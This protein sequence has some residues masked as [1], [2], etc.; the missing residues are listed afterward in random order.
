MNPAPS[1]ASA[2][3]QATTVQESDAARRR[4]RLCF[5]SALLVAAA[6]AIVPGWP[7]TV[8]AD[9][10]R[11]PSATTAAGISGEAKPS[12]SIGDLITRLTSP[13]A[14]E[15]VAAAEQL[16]FHGPEA[17]SAVPV[18]SG[19]EDDPQASV[20]L[21]VATALWD[22][23]ADASIP[24]RILGR[25]VETDDSEITPAAACV[26][27]RMGPEAGDVLPMLRSAL[28]RSH[29]L[30]RV[31]LAEAVMQIEPR[32]AAAVTM[33]A[34]MLNTTDP[35]V[36]SQA[37]WALE[38]APRDCVPAAYA[39]LEQIAG[40]TDPAVKLAVETAM[41]TLK[42]QVVAAE[43]A[44]AEPKASVPAKDGSP[45][46]SAAAP[47]EE[48]TPAVA[49]LDGAHDAE[50]GWKRRKPATSEAASTTAAA[51]DPRAAD[52]GAGDAGAA[53]AAAA[54]TDEPVPAT[55]ESLVQK[56]PHASGR[57]RELVLRMEDGN[58]SVRRECLESLAMMED[59]AAA[60]V[61]AI[62]TLLNEA[63]PVVQATAAVALWEIAANSTET[64]PVLADLLNTTTP[65]IRTL[66]AFQ[67]GRMQE[68]AS[69][70]L[71]DLERVLQGSEGLEKIQVAEAILKIDNSRATATDAL[72]AM[73]QSENVLERTQAVYALAEVSAESANRVRPLLLG[74]C[75]DEDRSVSLAAQDSLAMLASVQPAVPVDPNP[76][77]AI[78]Q[79]PAR[80]PASD[81]APAGRSRAEA[82][83]PL[84]GRGPQAPQP[85]DAPGGADEG[86]DDPLADVDL[87][88][89]PI[90]Q[91]S[92]DIRIP[93]VE[94]DDGKPLPVPEDYASDWLLDRYPAQYAC[95]G[96]PWHESVYHWS[97]TG[98]CHL[99]LYFEET[100]LERY[101][102]AC[103]AI[104]PVVSG[105]RFFG[106]A[107]LLPYSMGAESV[108]S[109]RYS[110]GHY[111]PGNCVPLQHHRKPF[112]LKGAA[113]QAGLIWGGVIVIH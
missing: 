79:A 45:E 112:S 63:D 102:Y 57:V 89:T 88:V 19:L 98:F 76:V 25:L 36:R 17:A 31:H 41:A 3:A 38:A 113:M 28:K 85:L 58:P 73:L 50:A 111:R 84:P 49:K 46:A 5:L 92:I 70:A 82:A 27:R 68:F 55:E 10:S 22:I 83:P 43:S 90:T 80:L 60:A 108:C 53:E 99:P 48:A 26:L 40:D 54:T 71:P 37:A 106:N 29:G 2:D 42:P 103:R 65:G 14:T 96:R 91:V 34:E 77:L 52:A 18:L 94:G 7:V 61:P 66:C 9:G 1:Q 24:V 13:V 81:S 74:L 51:D 16:G 97:A 33:L 105:A 12:P 67:L 75:S 56:C 64:V 6:P 69:A 20:R 11:N 101:G 59:E 23:T 107:A 95:I 39:A 110:L 93:E 47:Q 62:R 32:D 86:D 87:D 104:Q 44:V 4:K 35:F 109:R 30:S 72:I 15:R 21:A 8:T 78:A 100:S